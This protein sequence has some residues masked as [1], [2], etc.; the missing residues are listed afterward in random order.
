M[1]Q[2]PSLSE[3]IVAN[4]YLRE[5]LE[6]R[7]GDPLYIHLSDLRI[8]MELVRTEE[9]IRL[10]D[11]GAGG[12]PY[13]ALFPG[14]DYRRADY[15]ESPGLDYIVGADSRVNEA[16]ES[17]DI[18]LST[19]VLE[20]VQQPQTYLNEAYRLLKPGGVFICTTHGTYEEHGCPYDFHRWT[21]D[22]LREEISQRG[23]VIDKVIKLTTGPRAVMFLMELYRHRF[24]Q[25][26][27]EQFSN[28]IM[29]MLGTIHQQQADFHRWSDEVFEAH[30]LTDSFERE[31][32]FYIA[33]MAIGHKP[34]TA[35]G[36]KE[37]LFRRHSIPR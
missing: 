34:E 6:P 12:S 35:N 37:F 10:L 4:E 31:H 5:R 13:R 27:N 36:R 28:F 30:R 17:F 19:Q 22:G 8:G 26:P 23:F 25:L 14:A 11:Y 16:D 18:V 15:L 7:F 21:A 2:S 1:S 33:L 32:A 20:H 3:E 29:T 24:T 9:K